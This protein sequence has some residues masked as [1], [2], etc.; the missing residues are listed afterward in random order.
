MDNQENTNNISENK[1]SI[2]KKGF[3]L[4]FFLLFGLMCFSAGI[5]ITG[6]S[7]VLKKT[8]EDE[9]V[10]IGKIS[11]KYQD[12]VDGKL[13]QDIDF[14]LFWDVWEAL[15]KNY[16][17]KEDVTEKK[18]F[19]GALK[20]LANSVGDPYTVFMDPKINKEF[21]EDL[22]GT[23][24]GIGAEIGIK[25][26]ILTII[27]PLPDMPAEKA[28]LMAGDKVL[29]INGTST[30]GITIDAAVNKIRGP[31]GTDVIL[32]ITRD[33]LDNIQ[34]ITIKR[35]K[36]II[37]SIKTTFDNEIYTIKISNFGNDTVE[38][39]NKATRE[40]IEKNPKGIILDLRNNPGGYLET[41]IEIASEW[42]ENG[43]IVT[44]QYSKKKGI[45]T[46]HPARGRARIKNIP[47]VVLVNG[48][49]ASA[50]E[51]VAGAL[52]D[53]DLATIVGK[54][55]FGKGSVQ[56]LENLSDG[57]S[58]KITVAKWLTPKGRSINDEGITPDIII[59]YTL[60]DY[61]EDREP[62][63]NAAIKILNGENVISEDN[64][65]A[66]STEEEIKKL[67]IDK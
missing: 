51:I 24:E 18:M 55:T 33:G 42:V 3:Y 19:Y 57:S 13:S 23:F 16:V 17:D 61:E 28:G 34:D 35:G 29:A 45:E 21:Q 66:S 11:G 25:N 10:Y 9:V 49:S 54:Q 27:A 32:S 39:F 15:E 26:D 38:L 52:Q 64:K 8:A 43:T 12:A 44:E 65:T 67:E 47:T 59:D 37:H 30:L 62:Q 2:F 20:G 5:Y 22:A 41:A 60:E 14:D 63:M 40:I 7:E 58:L 36:I 4:F 6:K 1:S 50:S 31:K 48:G 53:Y 46:P 56:S